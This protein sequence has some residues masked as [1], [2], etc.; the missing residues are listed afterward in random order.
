MVAKSNPKIVMTQY[1]HVHGRSHHQT[2]L[3]LVEEYT[4][5]MVEFVAE[6]GSDG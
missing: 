4:K 5:A 3:K 2:S 1:T 6:G